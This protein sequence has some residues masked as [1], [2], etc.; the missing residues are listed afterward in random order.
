MCGIDDLPIEFCVS[1]TD[2]LPFLLLEPTLSSEFVELHAKNSDS[3]NLL[4]WTISSEGIETI[5]LERSENGENFYRIFEA[6]VSPV[7]NSYQFLDEN[8]W[9]EVHYYRP[10]AQ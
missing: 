3:G 10:F 6:P 8:L 5:Y 9:Q 7:T 1:P 2:S 4:N